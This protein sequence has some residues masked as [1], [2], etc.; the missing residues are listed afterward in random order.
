MTTDTPREHQLRRITD[1]RTTTERL[2]AVAKDNAMRAQ[3]TLAM[4]DIDEADRLLNVPTSQITSSILQTVDL[5][6]ETAGW[7]LTTVAIALN[8]HSCDVTMIG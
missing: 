4:Q 6:L 8:E 1:Q 7:R 2:L 3:V 5:L